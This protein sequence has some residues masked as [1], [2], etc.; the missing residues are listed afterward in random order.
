MIETNKHVLGAVAFIF[1]ICCFCNSYFQ[2]KNEWLHPSPG[3]GQKDFRD[4]SPTVQDRETNSNRV[5]WSPLKFRTS[6]NWQ[7]DICHN[8]KSALLALSQFCR[9]SFLKLMGDN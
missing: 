8:E 7:L 2:W 9:Y 4:G 5:N 6:N 3:F 1:G